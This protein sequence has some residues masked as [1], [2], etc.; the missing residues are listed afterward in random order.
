MSFRSILY[1]ACLAVGAM[2]APAICS[3]ALLGVTA[4]EP[5]LDV[6]GSA[7][8]NYNATTGVVT[9]SGQPSTLL[10]SDPFLFGTLIGDSTDDEVLITLQF[11]IN[12]TGALVSGVDGPD[13]IVKGAVDLDFDGINDFD[14]ILLQAEVT[15]FG[16][17]NGPEGSTDLFD[18]RLSSVA[19]ILATSTRAS[20]TATVDLRSYY[21]GRDL[22]F[23]IFSEPS[24]EFVDPFEGN[25]AS[26]FEAP[27]KGALGP[28]DPVIVP[29]CSLKVDATCSVAGSQPRSK[30]RIKV[31]KSHKHWELTDHYNC[32]G[33]LFRRSTY[34]MH[35]DAVPSWANR[36]PATNVTFKYVVSNIGTTPV[37][38][39]TVSDAF[40]TPVTGIPASLASGQSVTLSRTEALHEKLENVVL[41]TGAYLTSQCTA[42]DTV[43]IKD[44]LRDRRRHDYDN[45]RDKGRDDDH[46]WR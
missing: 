21:T 31:T 41:V 43:V 12:S 32:R 19:G 14:G 42:T 18:V 34:G 46:D 4:G 36:Y 6:P 29:S 24:T 15:G 28:T 40:D 2:T 9:I 1:G 33:Q 23:V 16:F 7:V 8:I 35:G 30:C 37:S 11:K 44:K 17:E 45:F 39:L 22:G 27:A 3:A 26:D 38:S 20:P 10:V 5:T 13:L 25:F